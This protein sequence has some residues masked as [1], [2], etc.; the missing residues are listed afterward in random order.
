MSLGSGI[1]AEETRKDHERQM[2]KMERKG[3]SSQPTLRRSSRPKPRL[4]Q[5]VKKMSSTD[6]RRHLR[7]QGI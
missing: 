6:Y 7:K 2:K 3:S 4:P 5:R 1:R